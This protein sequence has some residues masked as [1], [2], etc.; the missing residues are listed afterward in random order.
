SLSLPRS[1]SSRRRAR[2]E[3]PNCW[4][5]WISWFSRAP[6]SDSGK[7]RRSSG[8]PMRRPCAPA[9][10]A[11][12]ARPHSAASDCR[13]ASTFMPPASLAEHGAAYR[14]DRLQRPLDEAA[15]LAEHV[16]FQ[17]H[18]RA[19]RLGL[20][21]GGDGLAF[22]GDADAVEGLAGRLAGARLQGTAADSRHRATVVA[23]LLVGKGLVA[24]Q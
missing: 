5:T 24:Q 16:G 14:I 20:A 23:E 1:S 13:M 2:L 7:R 8:R 12:E 21:V 6:L 4:A 10:M 15:A 17:Q 3:K 9:T 19:Q 18:A 22:Q 11:S